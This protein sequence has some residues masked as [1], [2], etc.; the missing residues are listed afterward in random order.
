MDKRISRFIKA[1]HVMTLATSR[2]NKPWCANCFYTLLEEEQTLV[3]SSDKEARHTQEA[4]YN[5]QVAASIVLETKI[6]GKIQGVQIEGLMRLPHT[7]EVSR[8]KKAYFKRFPYALAMNPSLWL[9][10][11]HSI[12]MTH[13]QLGFGKKLHW[14]RG[15]QT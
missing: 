1:H 6:V 3:F 4:Q 10:E 7:D 14:E 5:P 8:T 13:N 15:Q 11:I 12:K 9:L 2:D